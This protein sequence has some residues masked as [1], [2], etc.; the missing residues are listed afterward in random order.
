[1]LFWAH[2]LVLGDER[3]FVSFEIWVWERR[4]DYNEAVGLRVP[5]APSAEDEDERNRVNRLY[6]YYGLV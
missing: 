5:A 4:L 6:Y 3:E 2:L 1:M